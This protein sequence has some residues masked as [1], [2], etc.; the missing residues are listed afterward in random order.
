MDVARLTDECAEALRIERLQGHQSW[1]REDADVRPMPQKITMTSRMAL[2]VNGDVTKGRKWPRL[3]YHPTIWGQIACSI[4]SSL[5]PESY[6][7]P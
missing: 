1:I 5:A 3:R 4:R 7:E 2:L 6:G